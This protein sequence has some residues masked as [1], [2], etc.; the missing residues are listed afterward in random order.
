MNFV[1]KLSVSHIGKMD[2]SLRKEGNY[3]GEGLCVSECP[4]DWMRIC[5]LGGHLTH[6]LSNPAGLFADYY[7]MDKNSLHQWGNQNG[8]VIQKNIYQVT[9][10]NGETDEEYV[11]E[12]INYEEAVLEAD[13]EPDLISECLKWLS[14]EKMNDL[15][16]HDVCI[17]SVDDYLLNAYVKHNHPECDGVWFDHE[18]DGYYSAPSGLIFDEKIH[19]WN[20][21]R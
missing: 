15:F 17:G 12:F 21:T 8:L 5:R 19:M 7:S 20:I 6:E 13:D 4:E 1:K 14:S 10:I 9:K 11:M 16:N 18:N 3:E 2:K